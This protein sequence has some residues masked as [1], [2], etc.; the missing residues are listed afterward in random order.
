MQYALVEHISAGQRV[1]PGSRYTSR[2]VLQY[3]LYRVC[4]TTTNAQP[5]KNRLSIGNLSF[6]PVITVYYIDLVSDG[7]GMTMYRIV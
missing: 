1:R 7:Y 4:Y 3:F 2:L 6:K 5:E